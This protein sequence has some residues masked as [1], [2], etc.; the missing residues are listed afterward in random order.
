MKV[1]RPGADDGLSAPDVI[2]GI[3]FLQ[4]IIFTTLEDGGSASLTGLN[5][6][7]K[8]LY[9]RGCRNSIDVPHNNWGGAD[10]LKNQ[11]IGDIA[12]S[13]HIQYRSLVVD[14]V[15]LL[16]GYTLWWQDGYR[17]SPEPFKSDFAKQ[18]I[19]DGALCVANGLRGEKDLYYLRVALREEP[20]LAIT[21]NDNSEHAGHPI[22]DGITFGEVS[23]ATILDTARFVR[24]DSARLMI[25]FQLGC[26]VTQWNRSIL[27]RAAGKML[28]V[29]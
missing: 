11:F 9:L 24:V 29:I 18:A 16:F 15:P 27:C 7:A 22:I 1:L 8:C 6:E 26:R 5:V 25:A 3:P 23:T 17:V 14:S 21:L 13:L 28:C 20:V 2:D 4:S 10:D 19:L 12:G